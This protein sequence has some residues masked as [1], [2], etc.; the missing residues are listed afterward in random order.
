MIVLEWVMVNLCMCFRLL[1]IVIKEQSLENNCM[2][3]RVTLRQIP[4]LI[5]SVVFNGYTK[6]WEA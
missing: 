6:T 4:D 5:F 3:N 1:S 2:E